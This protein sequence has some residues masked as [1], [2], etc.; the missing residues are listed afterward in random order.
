[1]TLWY[2][3]STSLGSTGMS[4]TVRT[5]LEVCRA[6]QRKTKDLKFFR[7]VD[8]KIK[9]IGE[10]QAPWLFDLAKPIGEQYLK[11]LAQ[12]KAP[13]T[14][15]VR[16]EHLDRLTAFALKTAPNALDRGRNSV[17]F[18]LGLLPPAA[19]E[20]IIETLGPHAD[21]TFQ[22][23]HR[24]NGRL[25]TRA[26]LQAA[27]TPKLKTEPDHPF[28]AGDAVFTVGI[29]WALEFLPM[30]KRIREKTAITVHQV[31]HD[32]TPIVVPQFH[33]ERN[34]AV[35]REFFFNVST[36]VDCAWYISEQTRRDAEATQEAW[37]LP[38]VRSRQLTWGSEAP[39]PDP[40]TSEARKALLATKGVTRPFFLFVST[41]EAR[42]NHETVYRA[43]RQLVKERGPE[44]PQ[45]VFVGHGGWKRSEFLG[46]LHR[47]AVVKGHLKHFAASDAEL[48]ALYRECLFTVYPSLYEGWGLP[49]VESHAYGKAVITSDAPSLEEAAGGSVDAVEALSVKAWHDMLERY[50]FDPGALAHATL[51]QQAAFKPVSWAETAEQILAGV[52]A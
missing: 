38:L 36:L 2:D 37:R 35:Y 31:V 15:E 32:L 25:H 46:W 18:A 11:S 49:I 6:L 4:G 12:P 29:D 47:D 5:E 19:A 30:L 14:K 27:P 43:F 10:G 42:K 24:L 45:L 3:L 26:K 48:D 44:I 9:T 8:G 40:R 33:V 23:M 50:L 22:L 1:M 51:R 21:A 52:A 39:R 7:F 28:S 17:L 20:V 41:V 13:E 16:D 34:C